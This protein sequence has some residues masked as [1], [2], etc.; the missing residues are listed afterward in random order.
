M[1]RVRRRNGTAFAG[2]RPTDKSNLTELRDIGTRSVRSGRGAST[3]A[4]PATNQSL[5]QLLSADNNLCPAVIWI[6]VAD[7]CPSR[8]AMP[9]SLRRSGPDEFI[10]KRLVSPP[11]QDMRS[12]TGRLGGR[13]S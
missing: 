4:V 10:R 12:T 9:V 8:R 6:H 11:A 13:H 1:R 2:A 3:H 7:V 5:E